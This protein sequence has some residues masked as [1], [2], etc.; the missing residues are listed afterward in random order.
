MGALKRNE[1]G[2]G[3]QK[4]YRC[5]SAPKPLMDFSI[6]VPPPKWLASRSRTVSGDRARLRTR[7]AASPAAAQRAKAG[8]SPRCCPVL[9]GLRDRCIAAMLETRPRH[10]GGVEPPQPG[11]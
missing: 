10:E 8:G 3:R 9:R 5:A 11:L 4:L 6:R 7:R 2:S 1:G